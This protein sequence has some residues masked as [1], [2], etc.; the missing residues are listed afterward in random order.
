MSNKSLLE[1]IYHQRTEFLRR[2]LTPTTVLVPFELRYQ[3]LG[4]AFDRYGIA[5]HE[6]GNKIGV[7]GLR[8]VFSDDVAQLEVLAGLD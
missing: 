3:L 6:P 2:N 5:K 8:V 4:E 1:Q 7:M